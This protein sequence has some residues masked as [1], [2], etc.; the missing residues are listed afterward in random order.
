MRSTKVEFSGAQHPAAVSPMG[1]ATSAKL[2]SALG[3]DCLLFYFILRNTPA[4]G[5]IGFVS[6]QRTAASRV[7]SGGEKAIDKI[8]T[9]HFDA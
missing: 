4:P 3:S 2:L 5:K 6:T 7:A 8:K 1:V 9:V